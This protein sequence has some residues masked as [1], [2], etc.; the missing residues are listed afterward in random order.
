MGQDAYDYCNANL[1]EVRDPDSKVRQRFFHYITPEEI[2]RKRSMSREVTYYKGTT[3]NFSFR[4]VHPVNGTC[5]VE[6][7]R[8]S[9]YCRHC[10][11]QIN[12]I[13]SAG[14][15]EK[16]SV[17]GPWYNGQAITT[18]TEDGIVRN[19]DMLGLSLAER[20]KLRGCK[21][22]Y[23]IAVRQVLTQA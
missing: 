1:S 9:C 21:Q 17:V 2:M 4:V 10:R 3:T 19:R 11:D 6:S 23:F 16:L 22:P 5:Q 12:G 8:R 15:C 14:H 13:D 7:R 20:I 18:A